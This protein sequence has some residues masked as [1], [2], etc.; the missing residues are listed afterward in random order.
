MP[1]V[2]K[3]LDDPLLYIPKYLKVRTKPNRRGVSALVPM[4][5]WPAQKYYIENRTHRDIVL[6]ARQMGLSTGVLAANSHLV[7]TRPYMNMSIVTHNQDTSEFLL[8]TVQRFWRNLPEN[9]QPR[10]DWRSGARMRF[11]D[12]D[13][14][15]QIDSAESNAIGF[16]QTLNIAHLSELSRWPATKARD[17][18]AGI[19]QTVAEGGFI[20]IESTPKGRFGIF[21]E[22]YDAAKRGDLDWKCFFF[23]W[24]FD[25]NY[26][27]DI[28]KELKY[29]P[30]E[31]Q[32]IK[33]AN[34]TPQ[35]IAWRRSKIQELGD[36]FYQEYPENDVDCWLSSDINVFDGVAIRRYLQQVWRG[37]V[38]GNLTIWKDVLGGEKYVIGVDVA[39]GI[40]KGDYSVAAVINT[41]RNEYVAC[42]RGR[43]PPDLFAREL[44]RL[45]LR[46]NT[47]QVGVERASHGH[48]V[49]RTLLELDYPNLYYHVDYDQITGMNVTDP[50][51]KTSVKSKP[52]MVDTLGA[53]LRSGD[54]A[55]WSEN[56]LMEASGYV[57]E[58]ERYKAGAGGFDDEIDA[59]AIALQLREN[60]PITENI[61]G[62]VRS[63]AR[64]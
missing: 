28:E 51:W 3:E 24:W 42:L 14:L 39:A 21:Y 38:D 29:T 15:I 55:L 46:Y 63:Y 48:S 50:G 16:G 33:I 47:A 25:P 2:I 30:E 9:M 1:Y 32:L 41:R 43:I 56:F 27:L 17:L 52:I 8:G 64:I 44:Y 22:Y 7:F 20:T 58:G 19:T 49:L 37:K 34:L 12:L 6:K 53:A 54:L 62:T 59:V 60:T 31:N 26:H 35:Q 5:L 4:E 61:M 18:F 10:T 36:L 23:P 40:A 13:T 45:A 11:P 57:K